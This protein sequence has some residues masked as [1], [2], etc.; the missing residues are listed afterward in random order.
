MQKII[1]SLLIKKFDQ[2]RITDVDSVGGKNASLGEM[3]TQLSSK[4]I[5]V[6]DGFATTAY[7]F[8]YFL[9]YNSINDILKKLLDNL[10]RKNFSNLKTIGSQAR[11][12]I[13]NAQLPENLTNAIK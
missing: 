7:A 13:L 9:E 12:L 1:M 10:D 6:P 2:I 11:K 5:L 3:F 4:G 8:R